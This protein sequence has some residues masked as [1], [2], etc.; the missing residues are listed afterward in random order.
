MLNYHDKLMEIINNL[1]YRPKLL[2]HSCCGP[3]ST[4]VIDF[5][6]PY[7]DITVFFYNPNIEP[8]SEYIKRKKE[9]IRFINEYNNSHLDF[10]DCDYDNEVFLEKTKGFEKYPE[11][12]A[13]CGICYRLRLEKTAIMALSK[14]YDYFATTLTVSP[15]KNALLINE[16]GYNLEHIYKIKYLPGDFKKKEGYKKSIQ[17]SHEYNLYRQDYCGCHYANNNLRD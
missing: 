5:L 10:L 13:R 8:K 6:I 11:G 12:G 15:Y 4:Y 3:C 17:M 7:F 14:E 1:D 9:Q 16:I 2:L